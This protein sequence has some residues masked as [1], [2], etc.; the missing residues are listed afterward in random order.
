MPTPIFDSLP[1]SS[2]HTVSWIHIG[3]LHM[4]RSGEQNEIDLGRIVDEINAVYA[5][6]GVDFDFIP[7]ILLMTEASSRM[8]LSAGTW[9]DW[10]FPGVASS[11][12]TTCTRRALTT[13]VV[14]SRTRST[15]ASQL[16]P[17]VS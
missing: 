7:G 2:S 9:T 4:T 1:F 8:R 16:G 14:T 11:A 15:A 12:T 17:T 5:K 13:F 10:Q 6:G 3:D